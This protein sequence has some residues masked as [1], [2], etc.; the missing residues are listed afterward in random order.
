M[1]FPKHTYLSLKGRTY[2]FSLVYPNSLLLRFEA[3]IKHNKGYL[4]TSTAMLWQS[5]W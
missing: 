4:N 3:I 2:G 1:F 5:T